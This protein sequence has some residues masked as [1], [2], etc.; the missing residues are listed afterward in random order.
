[1]KKHS[2][3]AQTLSSPCITLSLAFLRVCTDPVMVIWRKWNG[4]DATDFGWLRNW[5]RKLNSSTQ[6]LHVQCA[7]SM[8]GSSEESLSSRQLQCPAMD[9]GHAVATIDCL[10]KCF[11]YSQWPGGK[12]G[13]HG[14]NTK[15]TVQ[16]VLI[17]VCTLYNV[18]ALYI[19]WSRNI[20]F[21]LCKLSA[22]E[23]QSLLLC[24]QMTGLIRSTVV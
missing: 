24:T 19:Q 2:E 7:D 6:P 8:S 15:Y 12:I 14:T 18:H 23:V 21:Y 10:L 3:C 1:M 20:H 16:C 9:I 13:K 22:F 4:F 5:I 17:I 11:H